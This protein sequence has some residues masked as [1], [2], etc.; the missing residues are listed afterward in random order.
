M[1]LESGCRERLQQS[2]DGRQA[3]GLLDVWERQITELQAEVARLKGNL[4][5]EGDCLEPT[6]KNGVELSRQRNQERRDLALAQ[7]TAKEALQNL[8][9]SEAEVTTLRQRLDEEVRRM[10]VYQV[11]AEHF[12]RALQTELDLARPVLTACEAV[13]MYARRGLVFSM[14]WLGKL[15]EAINQWLEAKGEQT[16]FRT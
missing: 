6:Q 9:E 3:V 7:G 14:P 5:F 10:K 8:D 4:E 16:Q 13:P 11:T 1:S 12:I 15:Y 2:D